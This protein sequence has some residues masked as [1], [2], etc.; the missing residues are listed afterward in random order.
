MT[1]RSKEPPNEVLLRMATGYRTTQ[2]LYVVAKL[3][4]PDL[5]LNGPKNCSELGKRLGAHSRALFRVMRALAGLGVFTQDASGRFGLTTVS[6]LLLSENPQSMRSNVIIYGSEH[7]RAAG[8]L[9]HTVLTGETAFNHVYGKGRFEYLSENPEAS[10]NFNVAIA[11]GSRRLKNPL[12]SYDFN[13]RHLIIDIGGG[14]GDTIASILRGNP[15]LNGILFDLPQGTTLSY[16]YLA[17]QGIAERCKVIT[18]SAF[19]SIPKGGDV[20]LMSRFLHNFRD[21]EVLTLLSN[22]RNAIRKGGILLLRE[23]VIPEGGGPS[24]AKQI[25]LVMLFMSGGAE[26][27]EAEWRKL[28][29]SSGFALSRLFLR[30]G[31]FDLIEAR[32]V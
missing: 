12:E 4:I 3:G 14:R 6:E 16:S 28:L 7:Y 23:S 9:L 25:D 32:P 17:E 2:A 29:R 15:T 20:Y 30:K 18:G 5:L 27:T 21:V 10:L 31:Y 1:S 22:C 8:G 13:G 11:Q 19:D 26:R 24:K